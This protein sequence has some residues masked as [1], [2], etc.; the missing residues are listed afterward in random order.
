[1]RILT[2]LALVAAILPLAGCLEARDQIT[3][4]A[5][6][7]GTLRQTYVTDLKQAANLL[8]VLKMFMGPTDMDAAS[9]PDPLAP[10]WVKEAAKDVDGYTV[11]KAETT[12]KDDKRT[13]TVE[14]KFTSLAAAAKATAFFTSTVT[15]EKTEMGSWK[16]T[17]KDA[18][19]MPKE[20]Q[21]GPMA[22]LDVGTLLGMLEDQLKT[23][24]IRRSITLPTTIIDTNGTK[25]ADG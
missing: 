23:L 8:E 16:L 25:S 12:T 3:L 18:I 7:S 22:G 17:F 9:A 14:A 11:T 4:A 13:T 24:S 5:D 10:A 20:A 21:Q 1:M 2:R 15:L 6:G 19:A